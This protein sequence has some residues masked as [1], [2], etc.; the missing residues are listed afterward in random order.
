MEALKSALESQGV[1]TGTVEAI[2]GDIAA[3][4]ENG[5]SLYS[6][7]YGSCVVLPKN[8]L[9][10]GLAAA[11]AH[12]LGLLLRVVTDM[13]VRVVP[14]AAFR[15]FG[16]PDIDSVLSTIVYAPPP[17]EGAFLLDPHGLS[18]SDV[19]YS[20]GV[21]SFSYSNL[22]S[23]DDIAFDYTDVFGAIHAIDFSYNPH[24]TLAIILEFL[25]NQKF[26]ALKAVNIVGTR[27]AIRQLDYTLLP[28]EQH[29]H[30]SFAEHVLSSVREVCPSVGS[31]V[32][33]VGDCAQEYSLLFSDD[34]VTHCS[35]ARSSALPVF[36]CKTLVFNRW[37]KTLFEA[38]FASESATSSAYSITKDSFPALES[39][40]V[41]MPISYPLNISGFSRNTPD[42]SC[43]PH[44]LRFIN[45]VE[46]HSDPLQLTVDGEGAVSFQVSELEALVQETQQRFFERCRIV[47]ISTEER[48][49]EEYF[50]NG[51][52]NYTPSENT[53][54]AAFPGE[55]STCS[56]F[57]PSSGVS[58]AQVGSVALV[59]PGPDNQLVHVWA[60]RSKIEPPLIE[61]PLLMSSSC[62]EAVREEISRFFT[63]LQAVR[64]GSVYAVHL[65]SDSLSSEYA[66]ALVRDCK[67]NSFVSFSLREG[68]SDAAAVVD[69]QRAYSLL[70]TE[71]ILTD[72]EHHS[73]GLQ[74]CRVFVEGKLK[75]DTSLLWMLRMG[76]FTAVDF[77]YTDFSTSIEALRSTKGGSSDCILDVSASAE[78]ALAVLD[79]PFVFES[80]AFG[81][82]LFAKYM[83]FMTALLSI[84]RSMNNTAVLADIVVFDPTSNIRFSGP[85][86]GIS[87]LL[88][89]AVKCVAVVPV[90]STAAASLGA[91]RV[92]GTA[93]IQYQLSESN[94]VAPKVLDFQISE[95]QNVSFSASRNCAVALP[96]APTLVP[97]KIVSALGRVLCHLDCTP[98]GGRLATYDLTLLVQDD[99][100][101]ATI[102]DVTRT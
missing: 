84:T 87:Y 62:P 88:S 30:A 37:D 94:A 78:H 65:L 22:C 82:V 97:A 101:S 17:K 15:S 98:A 1:P 18:L 77:L 20:D 67:Y 47:T 7:H 34:V 71:M 74:P 96:Q 72:H 75:A 13:R 23:L 59:T 31:V 33:F 19:S 86:E 95:A 80:T 38:L 16:I 32:W 4:K 46:L 14:D 83:K 43:R 11:L 93:K 28:S 100:N 68:L 73:A 36:Q 58:F 8:I 29:A 42:Y 39:I 41:N 50:S 49:T 55:A 69:M 57:F 2:I 66:N 90:L 5:T 52:Y 89:R 91:Q 27:A 21:L 12:D 102:C 92:R 48:H 63:P 35:A 60:Q 99:R 76:L 10:S 51:L 6:V 70:M 9:T 81:I 56:V 26:P 3:S 54:L 64:E 53:L 45:G 44:S 24:L 61:M 40:Y 25:A 85:Q 79:M